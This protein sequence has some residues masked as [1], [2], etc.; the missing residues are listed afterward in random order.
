MQ[1]LAADQLGIF[2]ATVQYQMEHV[3]GGNPNLVPETGDTWTVG[4]VISPEFLSNWVFTIDY[5]QFAIADTIGGIDSPSICFDPINTENVFCENISRDATGNVSE[6][7][8][9]TS[10]RGVL[11]TSGI[12]VQVQYGAD[13]PEI[14]AFP[15]EFA[16]VNLNIYWTHL[17]THKVQENVATEVLDCSGYFGGTCIDT[18][19]S[20]QTFSRNRVNT[21]LHFAS[22]SLGLHLTWRWIEGTHNG[23]QISNWWDIPD[24]VLAIPE[25]GNE[26]YLDIGF[27][28]EMSDQFSMRFGINNLLDNDPPQMADAVWNQT[29]TGLYDVFGRSYYLTLLAHFGG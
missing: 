6:I 21:N 13:L 11:E 19:I 8:E 15:G 28:Y 14:L 20:A 18:T 25:V 17:L 27:A 29:D 3:T 23:M 4:A 2:E 12:D 5:F 22:G 24:P 26:H 7:V 10:N 9:L 16:T 1:G